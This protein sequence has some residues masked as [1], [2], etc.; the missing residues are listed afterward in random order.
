M[1]AER[2]RDGRTRPQ[3]RVTP[4]DL[5][6][7][8]VYVVILN[9]AVEFLPAVITETFTMSLLTAVLLKLV[10]ELVV[11]V[12]KAIVRRLR[13]ATKVG[14]RIVSGAMLVVVL[15]GSK[16]LVL[17]LVAF[18][19]GDSVKLGGFFLVTGLI[20]VLML[21]RGGVRRLFRGYEGYEQE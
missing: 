11:L 18:F 1:E 9:L 16:F 2:P 5:V 21:G 17:E 7:I 20:I 10:L 8:L 3:F 12:K 6:D 15:P 4:L 13:S 14:Q 19:F